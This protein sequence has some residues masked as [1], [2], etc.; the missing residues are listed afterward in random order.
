MRVSVN[1]A[2]KVR[3][4]VLRVIKEQ[5]EWMQKGGVS[6]DDGQIAITCGLLK[7][8]SQYFEAFHEVKIDVAEIVLKA[9]TKEKNE[10]QQT[11]PV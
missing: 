7:A 6:Y 10:Q 9:V 11:K 3:V 5:G 8:V 2:E 4:E 1:Y